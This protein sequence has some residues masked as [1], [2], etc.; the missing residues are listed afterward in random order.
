MP[1]RKGE[2]LEA[3]R[4]LDVAAAHD[5]LNLKIGKLCRE[6]QLLYNA[7]ILPCCQFRVVL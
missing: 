7:G 3:D 2:A 1:V 5:I 6:T 4:E